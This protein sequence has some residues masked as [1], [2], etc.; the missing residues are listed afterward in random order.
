MTDY[1]QIM[2]LLLDQQS[3]RQ[4]AAALGCAPRT[5]SK[6]R[7]VL[8]NEKLITIEQVNALS[9]EDLDRFF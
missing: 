3:Y 5:I 1:R 9:A 7:R 8:E 4:I 2:R 6:A